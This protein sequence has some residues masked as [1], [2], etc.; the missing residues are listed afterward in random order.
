MAAS[1]ILLQER[2]KPEEC[3]RIMR[4]WYERIDRGLEPYT[5]QECEA[6][7]RATYEKGGYGIGCGSE[8]VEGLCVGKENCPLFVKPEESE[9]PPE[10]FIKAEMI[11]LNDPLKF[12]ADTVNMIHVG[13]REIIKI[14]YVS[15]LSAQLAKSIHLWPIGTSQ[16]GKSHSLY[17]V[18]KVLPRE[19]YETFTSASPLSLFYYVKR[20]GEDAL[21]GKL[22]FIDEVE[23]S[24]MALPMLRSLTGQTEIEP[25]HLSVNDAELLDLKIKGPRVVWFTSVKSFGDE[26]IRNRFIYVNPDESAEQDERVFELQKKDEINVDERIE[27]KIAQAITKKI[28]EDTKDLK[29][30]IPYIDAIQWPYKS[31]R[32]LFPIFKSFL[33][34]VTKI[35]YKK[36]EI[37]GDRI[38]STPE[39]FEITKRLWASCLEHI[40]YRVSAPAKR[41]L[42]ALPEDPE[43]AKTKSELAEETGYSTQHIG[44]LL[45][46]LE[47]AQ[48]INMRK[49][50][51]EGPGR[52]SWEY[53]RAKIPGVEEIKLILNIMNMQHQISPK[54]FNSISNQE[55]ENHVQNVQNSSALNIQQC[56]DCIHFHKESCV[57]KNP[58]FIQSSATYAETCWKFKPVKR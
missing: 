25:R 42:N 5:W 41:L 14:A 30:E 1:I 40:I 23:T 27:F 19:L 33:Q 37:K 39:D 16:K 31:R 51:R 26:Q 43:D 56:G 55:A 57:Q 8:F 9:I 18:L 22:I 10:A 47:E 32:W 44:R 58:F 13:D 52:L 24:R 35:N 54:K 3:L 7:I 48:L 29:V 36:R 15:A 4:N 50:S 38:F 12:I 2:R 28:I 46:E 17:S 49:R 21:N 34:I 53:W 45:E 6:T 11:L 20:Y